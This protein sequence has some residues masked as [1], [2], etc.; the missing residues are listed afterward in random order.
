MAL[1]SRIWL[2]ES[3][4]PALSAMQEVGLDCYHISRQEDVDADSY[5]VCADTKEQARRLIASNIPLAADAENGDIFDCDVDSNASKRPPEGFIHRRLH[6][7]VAI[8]KR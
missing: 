5:W 6:G 1:R 4:N 2:L 3:G 8:K 7:P